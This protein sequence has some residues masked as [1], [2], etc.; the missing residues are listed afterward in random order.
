M[1]EKA[2]DL[3]RRQSDAKTRPEQEKPTEID[4]A[5]QFMCSIAVQIRNGGLTK[6][7]NRSKGEENVWAIA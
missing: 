2:G 4:I 7:H 6:G 3:V 1:G 5:I